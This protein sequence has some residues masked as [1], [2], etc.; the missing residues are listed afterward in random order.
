MRRLQALFNPE[1]YHG[2]GKHKKYFEG[3]YYKMI[4]RDNNAA[5]AVIPGIGMDST[6]RQQAFVQVLDGINQ[7]SEY[8]KFEASAFKPASGNFELHIGA[9][10]FSQETISL[11]LPDLKGRLEFE[12]QVAWPKKWY[13]P[14]IMGPFT[15]VPLMECYHGIL[16]MDH[17]IKGVLTFHGRDIDFSGGAGYMEK[18]WGHSFPS[19]YIW[20]QSNHFS[21]PGISLK[22]SVA[23]IPWLGSS[24]T[25]FI[26]G[27]YIHGKLISFT[28]YN[29]GK[30]LQSFAD[31]NSV[32]LIYEN[33]TY[34]LEINAERQKATS[35]ASP[36]S[37]FMDGRINE[38]MTDR[39]HFKLFDKHTKELLH[40]DSGDYAAVEVAGAI[41][42]IRIPKK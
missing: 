22:S 15:F 41:E 36:V 11:D 6:G 12:H 24:F 30:L 21:Q 39:I 18:D 5:I 7:K 19:A 42:E 4:N 29:S 37:G 38:S 1:R 27:L 35:L 8:H 17:S 14:G 33:S 10:Y 31:K 9:N 3:W 40:Q 34:R 26:A 32:S 13:S 20:M 2:W 23:K 16:S 28:T 25:G